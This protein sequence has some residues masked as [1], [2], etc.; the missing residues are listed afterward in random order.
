MHSLFGG[1][2]LHCHLSDCARQGPSR[3]PERRGV[4]LKDG[5]MRGQA[6]RAFRA[7]FAVFLKGFFLFC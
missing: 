1:E 5:G 3:T 6:K 7:P 4:D 2:L